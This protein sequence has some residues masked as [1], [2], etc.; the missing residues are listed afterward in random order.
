MAF[1]LDITKRVGT[2]G[3]NAASVQF[4]DWFDMADLVAGD[5]VIVAASNVSGDNALTLT[6]SSGTWERLDNADSSRIGT[7]MRSQVWWSK[8]DGTTAITEPTVAGGSS[9]AWVAVAW[10]VR[11]APN[12]SDQSWIDV[13]TRTDNSSLIRVHTIPSVTTTVN[14]CI[15][16]TVFTSIGAGAL[17]TPDR[18]WGVDFATIQAGDNPTISNPAARITVATRAAPTSG[19]TATYDYIS[20]VA[21]GVRSQFW[22]IAVKN[23]SGGALPLN[24]ANP[25]TRVGDFFEN[26]TF[27]A[28]SLT[29]LSTIHATIDGQTTFA[30]STTAVASVTGDLTANYL[31]WFRRITLTPPTATTGVSGVRW[32]LPAATD[33]T[34]G[35]WCF[36]IRRASISSDSLAGI[37]HYFED[38]GG[39]WAVYRPLTR[40]QGVTFNT[41]VRYLPDETIVD[42]SVTPVDLSDI[43]KRGIAYR[44]TASNTGGRAF[45]VKVECIQPFASPLTLTGGGANNPITARTVAKLLQSGAAWRL[46]FAQGQGQQVITQPYQLGNGTLA[47]YV[48]DEAQSLEY[49]AVG[50]VLGYT[51]GNGRQEIRLKASSA[52]TILLDAGIKGTERIHKFVVDSASDTG[53]TYGFAGTFLGW[54]VAAKTGIAIEGATFIGCAEID[55]KGAQFNGCTIKETASTDAA[56]AFDTNSSMT[57]TIIDVTGTSADFHLEL[58]ASVTAFT[59]TDVTFLGT[60]GTDKVN[61]K[62]T[63][64]TVDITLSNT[65]LVSSD[66][67]SAGATVNLLAPTDDLTVTS[68]ES[69]TLLQ[70]F[71]TGTQTVLASIT[72]TTLTYTHSSDTVDIVAQKAGFLPQRITG[73]VLSGDVTQAFTLAPDY[74]YDS[75]HGLIYT[76]DASW[77]RADNELTVPNF[78]PTVRQVY[79]LM[80]DAFIA[81]SSLENTAFNL[82]MNGSTSLFL[83]NDAGGATDGDIENMTGGGVRYLSSSDVVTAEFVGVQSQGVVAG[84]QPEFELGVGSTIE[85]ARATGDVNE[86]VKAYGDATHGNF[87]YRGNLQ[88]KVQRNGYRQAEADVLASY[89]I[90]TL[91]PTLYIITLTMPEIP[92]LTLG[93]PG[94]TGLTLTDDSAAPVSW[95]AGDGAKDYSI[96]ITDTGSNSGE[97]ILRWLNYNLSLDAT[98]QGKDPFYWPE[99]VLDNGPAYETLIGI[100]HDNPDVIAGVRVIVGTDPHPAFTRF[101]SDDGTYGTPPTVATASITGILTGSKV[102]IYNVTTATEVYIDSPGT[103]YSATY[104]DG[105]TYTAGDSVNI[106]IHKRGRLTFETTVIAATSGW[107]VSANQLED[108]VYTA[109]AIDGSTVTGFDA[110]YVN[111]EVNVTVASNFNI[112]DMYAWWSYNLES[113]DGIRFFVGGITALDVGNFRINDA[114]VDIYIDN[115]TATNLQQID[116]RRIFRVDQAYPVK[117]SGGGGIDVVWRNTILT[118]AVGSGVT[119]QDKT[120]IISGVWNATLA[121]YQSAGSTGEAL[122][123]AASGG[124]GGASAADVW[125]Y[126]SRTLTASSDPDAATIATAV[127]SELSTELGRMDVAVSTRAAVSD[128]PGPAPSASDNATAVLLAAEVSPIRADIRKVNAYPIKGTGTDTDPWGPA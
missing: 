36:L 104:T 87:D 21:N 88:F 125:T 122:D 73:L 41:L 59:L 79:S 107:A 110:D 57:G 74:N 19:A 85:D 101:Q 1:V 68:N 43:T 6:S 112:A 97:D 34:A 8:Y 10:V 123:D 94:V 25:P 30:A 67:T 75:G 27:V 42:G 86:I 39:N 69:G 106:R 14:D 126:A 114:V 105:T 49:P 7:A 40:L 66:I 31:Q 54:D 116:N 117:S 56:I 120:D 28:G 17:E 48:D 99:M 70:I 58:G 53:A 29:Q 50:G 45:D 23:K 5:Y 15:L 90:A 52:D 111:T 4:E 62:A 64:G 84:S 38:S 82:T 20:G 51:V 127:R 60:P 22:T 98:F 77:S 76:T 83:T 71:T 24:V 113:D 81:E 96:T 80:I 32:D 118:V 119:P 46:A 89:G 47:T 92:G 65:T 72:G 35:L 55:A 61:V 37:Y 44:Q 103:S 115:T 63:T 33:Y 109:L 124:G 3:T 102:R 18:F 121:S 9:A 100:L 16:L 91:E 26:N 2:E 78:G 95:D 13:N 93:D 128:L 108:E 12:V 11:D